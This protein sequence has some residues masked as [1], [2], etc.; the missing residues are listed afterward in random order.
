M[1]KQ[2][3]VIRTDFE[4]LE[5]LLNEI[6]DV[7]S[8]YSDYYIYQIFAENCYDGALAVVILTKGDLF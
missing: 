7:N 4:H 2:F 1:P 6:A 8:E 5:N 3:K